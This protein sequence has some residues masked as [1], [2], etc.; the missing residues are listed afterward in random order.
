MKSAS[1]VRGVEQP[2]DGQRRY[3]AFLQYTFGDDYKEIEEIDLNAV[4]EGAARAEAEREAERNYQPGGVI[5]AVE[6]RVGFYF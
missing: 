5:V 6:E 4:S 2:P 1:V 3:T